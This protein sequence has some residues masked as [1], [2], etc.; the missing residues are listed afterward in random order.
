MGVVN[1][2]ELVADAESGWVEA[3]QNAVRE[4]ARTVRHITGVEVANLTA[5]VEDGHIASFRANVNIAFEVE[6]QV[7]HAAV[8]ERRASV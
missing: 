8:P 4:A 6:P 3:V 1:V 2:I 5:T 7:D